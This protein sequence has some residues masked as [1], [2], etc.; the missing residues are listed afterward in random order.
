MLPTS[1]FAI[2]YGVSASGWQ[3]PAR[4]ALVHCTET[5]HLDC[6][7]SAA[8]DLALGGATRCFVQQEGLVR[9]AL[10]AAAAAAFVLSIATVH[11]APIAPVGTA[12]NPDI[13]RVAQGCGIG[14]HRG[15]FG[16]CRRNLSPAWPCWWVRGPFVRWR[17]VCH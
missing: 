12:A 5:R 17:L 13:V 1:Y 15:P 10:F 14:W 11:A 16:G 6:A 8:L 9:S 3:M 4:Q 7:A 2:Q